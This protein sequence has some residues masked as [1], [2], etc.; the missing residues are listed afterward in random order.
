MSTAHHRRRQLLQALLPDIVS[1]LE[2]VVVRCTHLADCLTEFVHAVRRIVVELDGQLLYHGL[3]IIEL[4]VRTSEDGV[5][6]MLYDVASFD[7]G[8]RHPIDPI[9]HIAVTSS[10][11]Q[12]DSGDAREYFVSSRVSY[13]YYG[14]EDG[15]QN[16]AES[17]GRTT[18]SQFLP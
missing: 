1:R 16:T 12:L 3:L 9:V 5:V 7:P 17:S 18:L 4:D 2:G 15:D 14:S 8:S 13:S 6:E 10:I 11:T